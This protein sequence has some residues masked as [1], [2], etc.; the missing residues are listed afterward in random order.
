MPSVIGIGSREEQQ[1]FI[2]RHASFF[3]RWP[4][5]KWCVER[6][7]LR[8]ITAR[9]DADPLIFYLGRRCFDDFMEILALAANGHGFGAM[10]LPRSMYEH[11]VTAASLHL[12][13]AAAEQFRDYHFIQRAKLANAIE[14]TIGPGTM[15]EETLRNV[16]ASAASV[17]DRYLVPH[18]ERYE[19]T[20]V[21]HSWTR[22]SF[23]AMT[24]KIAAA[25][26]EE[27][28]QD[29]SLGDLLVHAYFVPLEHAHSTLASATHRLRVDADELQFLDDPPRDI[30]DEAFRTARLVLLHVLSCKRAT[31]PNF[32]TS[33]SRSTST[34]RRSSSVWDAALP[35]GP[36]A[37][38]GRSSASASGEL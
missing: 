1:A 15:N 19:K 4:A 12:D 33:A 36:D 14:E 35:F 17:R 28:G 2:G 8:D 18:C 21:N 25:E 31:S 10:T 7:F 11:A 23:V 29:G 9:S 20:R 38:I 27:T 32:T 3:D 30:A 16:R 6:A 13:P 34:S 37:G 24:Q 22:L 26:R 5:L